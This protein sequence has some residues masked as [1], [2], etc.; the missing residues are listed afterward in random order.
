MKKL[1]TLFVL[2]LL[3]ACSKKDE[4]KP[5]ELI[6]FSETG[7]FSVK[8]KKSFGSADKSFGYQLLPAFAKGQIFIATQKGRVSALNAE[9]GLTNWDVDL[10]ME[11]SAGPGVSN[12]LL[13][14]A[15]PEG[16]VVTLDIDSGSEL[17]RATV[18]SEVL[19]PPVIDR[20]KVIIRTQDGRVYGFEVQSGERAWVFDT[21]IPNLTLRGTSTPI[22][23]G[24]R[25]YVGFDNGRVAA[26]D[27]DDGSVLWQ[28]DVVQNQGKTEIDRIADIDGDIDVVATDLYIASAANK[29]MSVATESGRVLWRQDL[30]SVTGVTVSRRS[31]YLSDNDS[32]IYQLN[33]ADGSQGW[34]QDALKYR[35]ITKPVFYLGDVIV[36]DLE[37]YLHI[38]DGATGEFLN[39]K[40]VGGK[41]FYHAPLVVG[42]VGYSYSLDGTLTAFTY[43]R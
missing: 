11:L 34:S 38:L 14:V 35:D 27:I 2:L 42:E 41:G 30:G 5:N 3:V 33:R 26:L 15:S 25:L 4:I 9:S 37:G 1:P 10:D 22:A 13:V 29:T 31:L 21:N 20:N 23:R 19:S 40:K 32:V 24:G 8:W 39:R 28:Q 7:A 16:E 36:G 17:W 18:T 43:Q 12:T 6:D